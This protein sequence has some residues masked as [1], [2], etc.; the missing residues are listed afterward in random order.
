MPH[1]YPDWGRDDITEQLYGLPDMAEL[2]ARLKSINTHDRHGHVIWMDDFEGGTEAWVLQ[3]TGIGNA[4]AWSPLAH[5]SGGFSVQHI[6]GDDGTM[7][8][9]MFHR[10]PIP[11]LSR[12]GFEVAWVYAAHTT[13][14]RLYFYVFD[15]TNY[16]AFQVRY[17]IVNDTWQYFN[18]AVAPPAWADLAPTQEL[19]TFHSFFHVTKLVVDA[20]N[21]EYVRLISDDRTYDLTGLFPPLV[22]SGFAPHIFPWIAFT[23]TAGYNPICYVDD[24]IITQHEP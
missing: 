24:V 1:G 12:L 5:R 22:G 17:D 8:S 23:G 18:G 4:Q 15:G 14:M 13:F 21:G 2:A 10:L 16:R 9:E 6:C 20:V 3:G 7:L 11:V 19:Y